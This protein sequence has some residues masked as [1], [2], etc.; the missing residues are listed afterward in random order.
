VHKS[1]CGDVALSEDSL[2]MDGISEMNGDKFRI[3]FSSDLRQI[4]CS[5]TVL[6]Q[7]SLKGYRDFPS[8]LKSEIHCT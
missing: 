3:K 7:F 4:I 6:M 1:K 2:R 8:V 5:H